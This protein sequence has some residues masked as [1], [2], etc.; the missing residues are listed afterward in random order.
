[1]SEFTTEMRRRTGRALGGYGQQL[2]K[3][4]PDT[5]H[6]IEQDAEDEAPPPLPPPESGSDEAIVS[7]WWSEVVDEAESE[8]AAHAAGRY[9]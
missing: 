5:L 1:M 2:Y 8:R 7:E 6:S 3:P 9:T 4:L